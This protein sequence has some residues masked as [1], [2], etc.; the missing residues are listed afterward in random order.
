MITRLAWRS[1]WRNRRRTFITLTSIGFGVGIALF[2]IALG[3]GM[4]AKMVGDVVRMQAGQVTLQH[5]DYE[6][7]PA[8]DLWVRADADLRKRIEAL[9]PVERTKRIISGQGIARSATGN[10]GVS[11]MGVDP[12]VERR[13]SPLATHISS[14][15]YLSNTDKSKV[16]IGSGLAERLDL[17]VGKKLVI[18]S[19]DA[20]GNLVEQLCRVKGIFHSGSAEMDTYFVQAPLEFVRK[21]YG[22]PPEAVT[23]LGVI[24]TDPDDQD[25]VIKAIKPMVAGQKVAVLP[26]QE[27]MVELSSYIS[28]DRNS[29]L[30]FQ[31]I[32]IFMI[33]FTIFN[34]L[35]MSVLERSREFAVLLA[36]GTSPGQL[37]A[38]VFLETVFL[39]VMGCALGL[40]MGGAGAWACQY[41]GV[42]LKS[43]MPEGIEISGF[44]MST[45]LY[46]MVTPAMVAGLGGLVLGMILL[47]GLIP[48]RRSTKVN[49][50]DELR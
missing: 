5:P 49:L 7:A 23:Q 2:F 40:A 26:W 48:V 22:L 32:L 17:E 29:N 10:V 41:Y 9:E 8:V 20:A 11:L 31:G 43:L 42:D 33:L 30:V 14:G 19:N 21:L 45:R 1:I 50:V 24:I 35:L 36:V 16:V 27:V 3:E 37:R 46:A 34:T 38:Q 44:A 39:G 4:Y 12:D 28:I 6:A 47:M 15:E 25:Q 13:L 18:T